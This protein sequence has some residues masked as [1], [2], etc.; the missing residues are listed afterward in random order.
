MLEGDILGMGKGEHTKSYYRK[1]KCPKELLVYQVL[2]IDLFGWSGLFRNTI[3]TPGGAK[4]PVE[5][6]LA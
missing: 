5:P 2:K 6:L 1:E 3:K 4:I